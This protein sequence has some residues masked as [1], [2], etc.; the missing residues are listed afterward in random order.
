MGHEFPN[1]DINDR[2]HRILQRLNRLL[3]RL[4]GLRAVAPEKPELR[5]GIRAKTVAATC[6]IEGNKLDVDEVLT[7][8]S[9][10]TVRTT[11]KD[12]MEVKNANAAYEKAVQWKPWSVDDLKDAHYLMMQ[13]L[14]ADAGKFR[15]GQAGIFHG[16]KLVHAAPPAKYVAGLVRDMMQALKKSS[17]P[18]PIKALIMHYE[19]EFIHPFA[20]GNGRVGRLWQ[21]V[22]L[23]EDSETFSLV[24]SESIIRE[25]QEQYYKLLRLT[26]KT[27]D[28]TEFIIFGLEALEAALNSILPTSTA[29]LNPQDR[30]SHAKEKFST[31]FFDRKAYLDLFLGVSTATASRDLTM[32]VTEGLLR[33]QGER[34]QTKYQFLDPRNS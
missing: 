23:L 33:K 12:L 34:N 4:E 27:S 6:A 22:M 3:G 21:H 16:A 13:G 18:I 1:I 19:L 11:G 20:D 29:I 8:L 14:I 31:A 30:L 15:T 10:K 28:A 9:G 7:V 5:R 32:G 25:Q 24:P 17:W 2:I 26:D